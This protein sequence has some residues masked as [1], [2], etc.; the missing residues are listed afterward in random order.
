MKKTA[1]Y[2]LL[3]ALSYA[4]EVQASA[5]RALDVQMSN[6]TYVIAKQKLIEE[7]LIGR[8]A[9]CA[10]RMNATKVVDQNDIRKLNDEMAKV[11]AYCANELSF[12]LDFH[13][14]EFVSFV[15]QLDEE[16]V[17]Q[18]LWL[19]SQHYQYHQRKLLENKNILSAALYAALSDEDTPE[20]ITV[21]CDSTCQEEA[22][23]LNNDGGMGVVIFS[24]VVAA[25]GST[26]WGATVI[27]QFSTHSEHWNIPM[28]G[29]KAYFVQEVPPGEAPILNPF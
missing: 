5:P 6:E 27:V 19:S 7:N 22:A 28:F 17:T 3:L 20:V 8:F 13:P 11:S 9:D 18:S 21:T 2:M 26:F 10:M 23:R 15:R 29:N 16:D 1:T 4:H 14:K 24:M 12:A 25:G